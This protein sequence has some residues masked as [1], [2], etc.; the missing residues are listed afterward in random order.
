MIEKIKSRFTDSAVAILFAAA[1]SAPLL[2]AILLQDDQSSSM[3]KRKLNP[4]PGNPVS[5]K[6]VRRYPEKFDKYYQ[7]SFGFRNDLLRV[8]AGTKLMIGDSPSEKVLLGKD[9]WLFYRGSADDDLFNAIRGIRQYQSS[10]LKQYA[11]VLQARKNWLEARGIKYVFVI[12]PNKHSIYREFL[13]DHLFQVNQRTITDEFAEYMTEHTSV[14]VIDLRHPILEQKGPNSLLYFRTDT[15]WN[16]YGSS[17]AQYEI[18]KILQSFFPEQISPISYDHDDF[19]VRTGTGGDLS[20]LIGFRDKF[21]ENYPRPRLD[22][23]TR[24]KPLADGNYTETLRTACGKSAI[25]AVVFGDSFLQWL[26]PYMSLYFNRST[27]IW[28]KMDFPTLKSFVD[29]ENPDVVIE[30]MV[31]RT[32]TRIPPLEPEYLHLSTNSQLENYTH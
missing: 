8:Y 13:P 23:C 18:A 25:N 3:E 9:G 12:A 32:L 5:V 7:D 15:H 29:R 27:Y 21:T 31:E 1:I 16:K 22:K 28:K 26:H 30:E 17:I 14:P 19:K 20:V 10:E 4:M 6:E 11:K 24:R 2:G